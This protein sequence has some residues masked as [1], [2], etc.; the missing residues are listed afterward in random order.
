MIETKGKMLSFLST[1]PFVWVL[2]L[3][4]LRMIP[5]ILPRGLPRCLF[6]WYLFCWDFYIIIII[7]IT[8]FWVFHTS[9]SWWFFHWSLSDSKSLQVSSTLL[10][11]LTDLNNAVVWMVSIRLLI[12]KS[13]N[14]CTNLLVTVPRAP[15]TIGITIIFMFHSFFNSLA[16]LKYLSFILLSFNLTLWSAWTAKFT[17]QQVLSFCWL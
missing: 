16:R 17:I 4:I 3:S 7:I 10:S 14:P 5:S 15:I 11:I 1:G 9:I 8:P 2:L 12:S 6:L 13:S